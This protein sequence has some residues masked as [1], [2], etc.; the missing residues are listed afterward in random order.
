MTRAPLALI[1]LLAS[2]M[3]PAE[4]LGPPPGVTGMATTKPMDPE[5]LRVNPKNYPTFRVLST[6]T[7]P[8]PVNRYDATKVWPVAMLPILPSDE[9]R[10]THK[11][12]DVFIITSESYEQRQCALKITVCGKAFLR[13]QYVPKFFWGIYIGKDDRISGGWAFLA[14]PKLILFASD[15]R[16][17]FSP[18]Q[19]GNIG[20]DKVRF[21][22]VQ[23][24]NARPGRSPSSGLTLGGADA[25]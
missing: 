2:C 22:R 24:T 25:Q 12:G 13:D 1:V 23:L 4:Y 7:P 9:W 6:A 21:E 20:W 3:G 5:D 15:R 14:N 17:Y 18:T 10:V 11:L 16:D 8:R 19:Q